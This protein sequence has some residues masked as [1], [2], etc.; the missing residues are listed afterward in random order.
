MLRGSRDELPLSTTIQTPSFAADAKRLMSEE[1]LRAL[2]FYI[3]ANPDAGEVLEGTGGARKL[4]WA[5]PG[6]GKSG[7]YRVVTF[8]I[9]RGL[10]VYLLAIFGKNERANLSK[11]ERNALRTMLTAI[12]Q[13]Y[14]QKND[15][16]K[17]TKRTKE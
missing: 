11:A 13:A 5:R 1:E 6:Q 16:K 15:R 17:K 10:P 12:A 8:F 9:D 14:R 2:E 7:G 3:A 4:R